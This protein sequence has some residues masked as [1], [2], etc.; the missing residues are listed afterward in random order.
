MFTPRVMF[1][2]YHQS[3]SIHTSNY[4]WLQSH[5]CR[6]HDVRVLTINRQCI[7]LKGLSQIALWAVR[8]LRVKRIFL[9][10]CT[11]QWPPPSDSTDTAVLSTSPTGVSVSKRLLPILQGLLSERKSVDNAGWC[12][13][14]RQSTS[15]LPG[16]LRTVNLTNFKFKNGSNHYQ[17]S[18]GHCRLPNDCGPSQN[19]EP[20]PAR[21]VGAPSQRPCGPLKGTLR[22]HFIDF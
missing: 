19:D 10:F 13:L 9:S 17:A 22:F 3:K 15:R 8:R 12:I 18:K 16:R 5:P 21:M 4:K 20:G 2:H 6:L 1:R 11:E 7:E 14:A